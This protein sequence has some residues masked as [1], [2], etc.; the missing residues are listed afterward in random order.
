MLNP[1]YTW[2]GCH[3]ELKWISISRNNNILFSYLLYVIAF[4][5]TEMDITWVALFWKC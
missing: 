5:H 4:K 1:I 2:N 3:S